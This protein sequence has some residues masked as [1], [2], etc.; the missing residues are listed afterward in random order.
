MDV[1]FHA[2]VKCQ[3]KNNERYLLI[4]P[5]ET[6]MKNNGN[7]EKEIGSSTTIQLAFSLIEYSQ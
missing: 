2:C 6:H 5:E 4:N 1:L 7:G 3:H